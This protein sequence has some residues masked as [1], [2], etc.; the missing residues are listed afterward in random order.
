MADRRFLE[1][2]GK[3]WRVVV[4][5][6]RKLQK[7][8]GKTRLKEGLKTEKLAVAQYKRWP[9]VARLKTNIAQSASLKGA[10]DTILTD[11][12]EWR[13]CVEIDRYLHVRGAPDAEENSALL[14]Q[15]IELAARN[16]E[17]QHGQVRSRE[18][19]GVATGSMTPLQLHVD[20]WLDESTYTERTKLAHRRSIE[21]LSEWLS[22]GG[23][24]KTVEGI[25]RMVAGYYVSECFV[26]KD[27]HPKTA[28]T[29]ISSLSSYWKWLGQKVLTPGSCDNPWPGQWLKE[30]PSHQRGEDNYKRPFTD[31]EVRR[32]FFVGKP[33]P[34]LRDFMMVAALTGARE[35]EIARL[36][37]GD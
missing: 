1:Q 35:D 16:I 24:P 20:R 10:T 19:H 9:V 12:L 15:V 26:Q 8:L 23:W 37:V 34:I 3:Q 5:V 11:A 33:E 25:N 17:L 14:Q 31:D 32:L 28:N 6:P 27:V 18:F 4:P 7:A 36:K 22:E 13:D 30:M 29:R 2:H 21:M